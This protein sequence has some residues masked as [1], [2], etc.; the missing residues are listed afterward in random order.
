M[1][2]K[3]KVAIIGLGHAGKRHL[4]AIQSNDFFELVA[5]CDIQNVKNHVKTYA[6]VEELLANETIDL[7]VIASP[8][9]CHAEQIGACLNA[10]IDVLCEKPLALELAELN[11]L[12]KLQQAKQ[13][14]LFVVKQLRFHRLF[15]FLKKE[16]LG[17]SLGKVHLLQFNLMWSRSLDYFK[18][19]G[20]HG[21]PGFDA[22]ILV[23]QAIH[24]F[25]LLYWWFGMPESV[26]AEGSKQA[27][28]VVDF[29]TAL[30]NFRWPND[31]LAQVNIS[32]LAQGENLE[33]TLIIMAEN[34]FVKYGGQRFTQTIK[35]SGLGLSDRSFE[36]AEFDY[37]FEYA[38][39]YEQ[40]SYALEKKPHQLVNAAAGL[41][42]MQMA[43][44]AL[45]A[46]KNRSHISF[47]GKKNV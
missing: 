41:G 7:V 46:I 19:E 42:A 40:I 9:G 27:R 17:R 15:S 23:N 39:L 32:F 10:G 6:K 20:W 43:T 45:E 1:G 4:W 12:I 13:R 3:K 34:G 2:V 21:Q 8:D 5:V 18:V 25:D 29:D 14:Q 33:S 30:V 47:E 35:Q 44:G 28:P 38:K 37:S 36:Q 22:G 31:T 24:Y 11:K 26:S 16:F